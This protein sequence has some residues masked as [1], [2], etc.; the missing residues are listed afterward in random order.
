MGIYVHEAHNH[1]RLNTN[2]INEHIELIGIQI[3]EAA[4][5][6]VYRPPRGNK[7]IFIN[8]II[9]IK[10]SKEWKEINFAGDLNIDI[11]AEEYEE[12]QEHQ[13][14]PVITKP[15][16]ITETTKTTIDNILTNTRTHTGYIIPCSISDHFITLKTSIHDQR[17]SKET[18][19]IRNTSKEHIGNL[20]Q[21]LENTNW[22]DILESNNTLEASTKL[23]DKLHESYNTHIPFK[24]LKAKKINNPWVTT[25]IAN[26]IKQE[27]KLYNKRIARNNPQAIQNHKT[28]KKIL[29]KTIRKART[30]HY[31]NKLK[32]NKSS[33]ETWEVIYETA[34]QK[35]KQ[36]R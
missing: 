29:D 27:R 8:K 34:K 4:Y 3:Q 28:Y 11:T 24:D 17:K 35:K 12:L 30:L 6:V 15:T 32:D 26:S 16:R 13:L 22:K 20:I 2:I 31:Q 14:L 19:Q 25:A 18:V 23:F 10:Q 7:N 33:R 9:E 21:D 1:K 36:R 5:F